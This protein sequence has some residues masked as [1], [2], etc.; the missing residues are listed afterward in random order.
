MDNLGF[1]IR[2]GDRGCGSRLLRGLTPGVDGESGCLVVEPGRWR[3]GPLRD[4]T[5]SS[6]L[7]RV[8][9]G[10]RGRRDDGLE[11]KS[12]RAVLDSPRIARLCKAIRYSGSGLRLAIAEIA[13]CGV[14][15]CF[16]ESG[17]TYLR[18]DGGSGQLRAFGDAVGAVGLTFVDAFANTGLFITQ[19]A[20]VEEESAVTVSANLPGP[21]ENR[22]GP[23]AC[24][25]QDAVCNRV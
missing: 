19:A 1:A 5:G 18:P 15:V 3:T 20:I 17:A 11:R 7:A 22:R 4:L 10:R 14:R 6:L 16:P 8:G 23:T 13:E 9:R 25:S 24:T 12:I 21:P 2:R